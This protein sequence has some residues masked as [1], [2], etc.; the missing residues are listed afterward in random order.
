MLYGF[1]K[2]QNDKRPGTLHATYIV[3]GTQRKAT[4]QDDDVEMTDSMSD[5]G[6]AFSDD[7]PTC[8]L[9]LV[10]EEQLQGEYSIDT[11]IFHKTYRLIMY[12]IARKV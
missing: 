12:R 6:I 8:T 5:S 11:C 4:E 7:V 3:Y 9:T 2:W 10:R 1:H